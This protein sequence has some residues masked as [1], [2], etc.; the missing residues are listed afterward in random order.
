ML[1][2]L[3]H[4][5]A[6]ALFI[7]FLVLLQP[8]SQRQIQLKFGN[9]CLFQ[10]GYIPL[11]FHAVRCDV[12]ADGVVQHAVAHR[13]DGLGNIRAFKQFIALLVDHLA[14]VVGDVVVFQYLLAHVEVARLDLALCIFNCAR[15]PGMLDGLAFRQ[16]E[17]VHD[18][19][20][21]VGGEDAQQRVFQRQI[22]TAG[23]GIALTPGT[24]AQLVIH[25]ARFMALGADDVQAAAG[26]YLLVDRFPFGAQLLRCAGCA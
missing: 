7:E 26:Y 10:R 11:L 19:G 1:R 3:Q 14:L 22:K 16:L 18:R 21:A 12:F 4:A 13:R 5:L 20:H 15:D 2:G 24:T 17:F 23:T 6:Q 9:Q 8:L 25:A